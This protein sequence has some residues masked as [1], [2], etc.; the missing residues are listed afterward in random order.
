M[1]TRSIVLGLLPF[2]FAATLALAEEKPASSAKPD[3]SKPTLLRLT[4]TD[5]EVHRDHDFDFSFGS[6][7]FHALGT[8][9]HFHYLPFMMPFP[10]TAPVTNQQFPDA[11]S[12]TRTSIATSRA[13]MRRSRALSKERRRIERLLRATGD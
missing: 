7:D 9:F 6:I 4:A 2:T 12:L 3:Y 11:F 1:R 13:A 5:L 8:Q 10:G